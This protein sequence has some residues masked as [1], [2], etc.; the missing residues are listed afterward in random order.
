MGQKSN[1]TSFQQEQRKPPS[2]A[3]NSN[4]EYFLLT[5]ELLEL[6]RS[7]S[8]FFEKNNSIVHEMLV[9]RLKENKKIFVYL[10]FFPLGRKKKSK[11]RDKPH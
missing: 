3:S 8:S 10:S 2:W 5:K 6:E 4:V 7:V 9:Y 1:P 11:P